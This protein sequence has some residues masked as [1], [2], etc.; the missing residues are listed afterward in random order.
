MCCLHSSYIPV[1]IPKMYF[2]CP[3]TTCISHFT[4][5]KAREGD[6]REVAQVILKVV[7]FFQTFDWLTRVKFINHALIINHCIQDIENKS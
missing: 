2:F 1:R 5:Q 3:F 6:I 4:Y 7:L